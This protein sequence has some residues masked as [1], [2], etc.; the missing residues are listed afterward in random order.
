VIDL[1]YLTHNRR[2]FTALTFE[3]LIR[4]TNWSLVDRLIVYDDYSTDGAREEVSSRIDRVPV[5]AEIRDHQFG[6]PVAV[7][8]DYIAGAQSDLF[9]KVDN[10]LALPP[11]WLEAFLS[12]MDKYPR[13]TLLGTESPFMGP[14][15]EDWDGSYT[16][17]SW[18][19]IGG[20]GLMRTEF[21]KK[22]G[23][24]D[25][26]GSYHGFT[27][28]QWRHAPVLGWI[29]PDILV[30]LLDRCPVEPWRSLSRTYVERGWQRKWGVIPPH[31]SMYWDWFVYD[32]EAAA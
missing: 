14:P 23:P 3:L 30:C 25:V 29:T 27:G 22:T 11:L 5:P 15:R 13:L 9:A 2:E 28:H 20:N 1:L 6:S 8:N 26:E 7:M 19:H 21:F 10:D 31:F 32:E 17:S 18:K 12:V 24:M 16:Y 4:N